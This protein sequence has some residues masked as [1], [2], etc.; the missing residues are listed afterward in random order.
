VPA[1]RVGRFGG[2]TV[3]FGAASAALADLSQLYR[4]AFAAALF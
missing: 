4:S 1:S 3:S 2:R